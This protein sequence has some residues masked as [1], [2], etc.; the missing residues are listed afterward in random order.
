MDFARREIKIYFNM[1]MR[2]RSTFTTK[3]SQRKIGANDFSIERAS[4]T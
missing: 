3:K 2:V 4:L 1:Q